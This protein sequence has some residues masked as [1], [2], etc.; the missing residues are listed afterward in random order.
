MEPLCAA[1]LRTA[2]VLVPASGGGAPD[3]D[4]DGLSDF[5]EVHKYLTDPRKADSDGDGIPD[6]DWNERREY[7]YSVRAVIDVMAPFDVAAM[8]DDYQDVRVLEQRPDLL[9]FEVV[10]YPFNTVADAIEPDPGW[11]KPRPELK[12]F[13]APGTC[14]NWDAEMKRQLEAD[15]LKDGIDVAKLDDVATVQRVSK[16]LNDRAAFDDSFTTFAVDFEKGVPRV[17]A[18]R[19]AD[20]EATLKEKGRTLAQQWDREL[21]GKGMFQN[22]IRGSCTSSA[23][24]LSTA[25][26]ALGI[27]TRTIVCVPV[28]D[29]SDPR[30]VAWIEPRLTHVGVRRIV[31]RAAEKSATSWTSHTFNE[32]FVGG[33]WRRLNYDRLGQNVLDLDFLGLMVHVHTF[34]DHAEAGLVGWGDRSRHPLHDALFGGPNP[35]SCASLSDQFGAHAKVANAAEGLREL[36]I[37]RVCW[38]DDPAR[39]PRLDTELGGPSDAGYFVAHIDKPGGKATNRDCLEF[40]EAVGKDFVLRAKGRADVRAHALRKY[41]VDLDGS[42]NDFILQIDPA[43]FSRMERGVAYELAGSGADAP[44]R[45]TVRDGVTL[46]RPKK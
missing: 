34:T 39:D 22:R 20:V 6:G 8:N 26:K 19:T 21:F 7:A 12:P 42:V 14:C 25:L 38:Y 33:R 16:W 27:P 13:L 46:T 44:L 41:W 11:R 24:Y 18:H 45:W 28:I 1:A 23:I 10:V 3:S 32:V 37:G 5:D 30:E 40:F 15:L 31:K 9:E 17:P 36:A 4:R 35:Y 29:A 2:L 43:E